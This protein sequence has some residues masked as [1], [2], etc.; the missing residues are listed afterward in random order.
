MCFADCAENNSSKMTE[1]SRKLLCVPT[2]YPPF[3]FNNL[4][5]KK[6]KKLNG[7][8]PTK[9]FIDCLYLFIYTIF[10]SL[11]FFENGWQKKKMADISVC[12]KI[13]R[14]EF[15]ENDSI[16]E[17]RRNFI[18]LFKKITITVVFIICS[19]SQLVFLGHWDTQRRVG[20]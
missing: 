13:P 5:E 11:F 10:F 15:F 6:K 20:V 17:D 19:K 14:N 12:G 4:K 1:E 9:W 16:E 3:W 8:S 7:D 2:G 18:F